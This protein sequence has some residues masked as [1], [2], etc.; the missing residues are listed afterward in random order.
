[1]IWNCYD[2]NTACIVILAAG[3]NKNVVG[4]SVRRIDPYPYSV[5]D[6]YSC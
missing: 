5:G 6:K 4:R 2:T 3:I 1:M